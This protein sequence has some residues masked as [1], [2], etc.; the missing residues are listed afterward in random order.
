MP[1]ITRVWL[2]GSTR[3]DD[4]AGTGDIIVAT[5]NV[6][7]IDVL[8]DGLFDEASGHVAEN[9]TVAPGQGFLLKDAYPPV[10]PFESQAL[11]NSSL[12]IGIR[13]DNAW[14]PKEAF[15]FGESSRG[16]IPL[17][18]E[19][20]INGALSTDPG[21][22]YLTVPIRLTRLGSN[23]M[24]IRRLLLA[25]STNGRSWAGTDDTL[26]L[27]IAGGGND[28]F[29]GE[30]PD[31][32]QSDQEPGMAD[33]YLIDVPTQF[34]R[35]DLASGGTVTLSI[36]GPDVWLPGALFLFGLNT[37]EVEGRPTQAVPLVSIP[38]W[39]LGALS[40]DDEEGKTSIPLP[41]AVGI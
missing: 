38:K 40:T 18:M 7:G 19:V 24:P 41:L 34:S 1:A 33:F 36:Q 6:D 22:G 12:R 16:L 15:L 21:E 2:V 8:N 26:H 11:T 27:H 32:P 28:L 20:D 5:I 4:T 35:S 25:M 30:I 14:K 39:S 23:N 3:N 31:N 10:R 13:G 17:G 29:Q 37:S 9:V